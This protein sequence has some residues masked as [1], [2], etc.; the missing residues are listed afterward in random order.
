MNVPEPWQHVYDELPNNAVLIEDFTVGWGRIA[1]VGEDGATSHPLLVIMTN[2]NHGP[3]L[4]F[5]LGHGLSLGKAI[6]E[7]T[8]EGLADHDPNVRKALQHEKDVREGNSQRLHRMVRL[9]LVAFGLWFI[10]DIVTGFV[11]GWHEG[12]HAVTVTLA[13][14]GY[15]VVL[16][17][18]MALLLRCEAKFKGW[19]TERRKKRALAAKEAQAAATGSHE[20]L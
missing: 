10:T 2:E 14:I 5:S 3:L 19:R 18:A 4:F 1:Q 15:I 8:M 7:A 16:V 12:G 6:S 13:F 9:L 11:R 20:P 17:L